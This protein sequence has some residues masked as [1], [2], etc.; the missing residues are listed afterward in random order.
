MGE[1]G[2]VLTNDSRLKRI[3]ESFR[4][5]GR[6]CFCP[7]GVDNTCGKRFGWQLGELPCGYD[8]KYTYSHVGYNLKMTDM[9]AAVGLAQL[10]KLPQFIQK[11]RHNFQFIYERLQDLQ[12]VLVL[13][14]ATTKAEP[15]WFGFLLLVRQNASFTRNDLVQHLEGKR[16]ATRLLFGEICCDNQHTRG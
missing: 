5:W 8:H 2:A 15:S 4:D 16:I 13:P 12:D 10:E 11:R 9:Q 1:G 6:D 7:P 14:E 3:V